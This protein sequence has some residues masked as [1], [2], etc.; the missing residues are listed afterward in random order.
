MHISKR[1]ELACK[2]I[3]DDLDIDI[4]RNYKIRHPLDKL[5][6]LAK[7]YGSKYKVRHEHLVMLIGYRKTEIH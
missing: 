6:I 7:K 4:Q 3:L 5:T 2:E 1:I